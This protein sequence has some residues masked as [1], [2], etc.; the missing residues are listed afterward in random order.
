MSRDRSPRRAARHLLGLVLALSLGGL[1]GC[2]AGPV[3]SLEAQRAVVLKAPRSP[4]QQAELG[5]WHRLLGDAAAARAAYEAAGDDPRAALGRALLALDELDA[6]AAHAEALRAAGSKDPRVARLAL[7]LADAAALELSAT[8]RAATQAR[9]EGANSAEDPNQFKSVRVPLGAGRSTV[10]VSFL[11]H[12]DLRRLRQTPPVIEAEVLR[13]LDQTWALRPEG[14]PP[15]ADGV[16]ITVWPLPEGSAEV[17]IEA[18]GPLLAWRGG[19]ALPTPDL[20]HLPPG[21][22]H[23]HAPGAGP[24]VVAWS[25]GRTP[26]AWRWLVAAPPP[27][28]L[29]PEV[30]GH[31]ATPHWPTVAL[32]AELALRDDDPERAAALLADAPEAP[33]LLTL[34]ARVA[35]AEAGRPDNLARDAARAVWIAA[36]PVAPARGHLALAMLDFEVSDPQAALAH[37]VIAARLAPHAAAVHAAHARA[38]LSLDRPAE[39]HEA[40]DAALRLAPDPCGLVKLR[41]AVLDAEAVGPARL[42][43]V[44]ELVRC[45]HAVSAVERLLDAHQPEAALK[46]L[47]TEGAKAQPAKR[48]RRLKARALVALGDLTAARALLDEAGD[49]DD[50]LLALDLDLAAAPGV[51]ARAVAAIHGLHPVSGA[52]LEVAAAWPEAAPYGPRLLGPEAAIAAYEATV[53]LAGPAVRVLDHSILMFM[54]D[55]HSL[56]HVNEV[57]AIRSREAAETYGEIT[58]PSRARVVSLYTRKA[59]GRRIEAEETPEKD[60]ITLR[61]L[62]VGDYV[63]A[64]WLEPGDNG[65]LYDRGLL[66][67]RVFFQ[68]VDLPIFH[69]RFEAYSPDEQVLLVHGLAGAPEPTSLRLVP[70]VPAALPR[71]APTTQSEPAPPPKP[72]TRE[73]QAPDTPAQSDTAAP[74]AGTTDE[75]TASAEQPL[76]DP[77]GE[78]GAR[79]ADEAEDGRAEPEPAV[80]SATGARFGVQLEVR[81][82]PLVPREPDSPPAALWLPSARVGRNVQRAEDLAWFRDRLLGKRRRTARFDAWAR[83]QAGEGAQAARVKRLA[84]AVREAVDDQSGLIDEEVARSVATGSGNRALVLSAA[85]EAIGVE[86]ELLLG[87]PAV[88]VPPGPF[89]V[90]GDYSYPLIFVARDLI[91]PGPERAEPGFFPATLAGGDALVLWPAEGAA[92]KPWHLPEGRSVS[93]SRTVKVTAHWGA[94]GVLRGQVED[95]LTGQESIVVGHHLSRLDPDQRPRLVERLLVAA[96]GGGRVLTLD[97]PAKQDPDGPLVLRYTF[98]A[99]VGDDLWLG[100]FPVSPGRSHASLPSRRTA[101]DISLPTHQTVV[102]RLTADRRFATTC[103]EGKLSEGTHSHTLLPIADGKH[104]MIHGELQ[105][106]KGLVEPADYPRFARWARRVDDRERVHL[107]VCP[108]TGECAHLEAPAERPGPP[109]VRDEGAGAVDMAEPGARGAAGDGEAAGDGDGEADEVPGTEADEVPGTEADEAGESGASSEAADD[110]PSEGDEDQAAPGT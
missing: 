14:P 61:D 103:H 66:S 21:R 18:D 11:P 77:S 63:V 30:A 25:S 51:P 59:D 33:G 37:L 81:N 44:P 65:Y 15:D 16:V 10:R 85:L 60:S 49:A 13:A 3:P 50:A 9:A 41:E 34:R 45:G 43:V 47:E 27:A 74:P 7:R 56:R 12:L 90:V 86:H 62:A 68:G 1:A 80:T 73:P 71:S 82:Q 57:L 76:R 24:L 38:A 97:D 106:S 20:A 52:A 29:A 22:T 64:A 69:Q 93:D 39:A 100:L 78:P 53:P 48:A 17:E 26:R 102:L 94:D 91:D 72:G 79:V 104:L 54:A 105:V 55:G 28:G 95:T 89:E 108:A 101:L 23:L 19:V 6:S 8:Q 67:Q 75:A 31:R 36:L 99:Q 2:G 83:A 4:A 107:K 96:V 46:I 109:L 70:P 88:K 98:E 35:R 58:L 92:E 87:R 84:R 5:D 40:L 42:A 110:A 32:L